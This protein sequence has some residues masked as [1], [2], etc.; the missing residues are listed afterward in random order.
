MKVFAVFA[1]LAVVSARPEKNN[2]NGGTGGTMTGGMTYDGCIHNGNTYNVGDTFEDGCYLCECRGEGTGFVACQS[3]PCPPMTYQPGCT[4][5]QVGC[6]YEMQCGTGTGT[7]TGTATQMPVAVDVCQANG[8]T[9]QIGQQ[10]YMTNGGY[11]LICTCEGNGT[12]YYSCAPSNNPANE[13]CVYEG[14]SYTVGQTW[15]IQYQGFTLT[16]T[17]VGEG[18]GRVTCG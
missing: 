3:K 14:Q 9:Y 17:C 4:P 5:V 2:M 12:G 15:Q 1:L 13:R 16:C 11:M 8:Q 7:G 18:T 6:C 10:W